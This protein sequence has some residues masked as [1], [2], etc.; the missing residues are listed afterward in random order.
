MLLAFGADFGDGFD[1]GIRNG[2]TLANAA[3]IAAT[4]A[5]GE[6]G[7]SK[8]NREMKGK[9]TFRVLFL[10]LCFLSYLDDMKRRVLQNNELEQR[11]SSWIDERT[12]SNPHPVSS[13][14][15]FTPIKLTLMT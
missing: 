10:P 4:R 14:S 6:Q 12:L 3:G 15:L 7:Q 1:V 8:R 2:N 9:A 11:R 13:S 5:V